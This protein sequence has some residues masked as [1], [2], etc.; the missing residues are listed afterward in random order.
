MRCRLLLAVTIS[1]GLAATPLAAQKQ[2]GT[3][4]NNDDAG[5]VAHCD[6]EAT[7]FGSE[8]ISVSECVRD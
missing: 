4:T 2:I 1:V 6:R 5:R 8:M 7:C 3:R